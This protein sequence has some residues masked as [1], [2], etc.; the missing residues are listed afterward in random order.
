M[1]GV[2]Y[3]G[4]FSICADCGLECVR[5]IYI[6]LF[7]SAITRVVHLEV[8]N[9]LTGSGVLKDVSLTLWVTVTS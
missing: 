4:A 1:T 5:E 3:T 9:D 6:V 7:A 2:D 8:V